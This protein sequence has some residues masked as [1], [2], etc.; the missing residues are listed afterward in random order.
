MVS[1]CETSGVFSDGS[2]QLVAEP[3]KVS[4]LLAN[5][6]DRA[7]TSL[8]TL[9][10]VEYARS[11]GVAISPI[12]NAPAE[13]RRAI[14]INW[15]GPAEPVIKMLA[16]RAGYTFMGVGNPPPT[17]IVVSVDATNQPVIDVLRD[18]GLQLGLRADVRVDGATRQ[19]EV[20][21]APNTGAGE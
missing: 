10:S 5:A 1:A 13:L 17:A 12:H 21:Y 15:V 2:P 8:E 9:A 16:D 11:S 20:H 14:T 6:A 4:S 3:D 7:A 18:I 19:V